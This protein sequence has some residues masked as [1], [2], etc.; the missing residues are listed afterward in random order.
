MPII[1]YDENNRRK[2]PFEHVVI[3]GIGLMGIGIGQVICF[4]NPKER[5][6]CLYQNFIWEP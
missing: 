5:F 1:E 6:C 2:M 4:S 3:H